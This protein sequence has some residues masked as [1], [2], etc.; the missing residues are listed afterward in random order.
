[1][2]SN[3]GDDELA[4]L[5]NEKRNLENFIKYQNSKINGLKESIKLFSKIPLRNQIII[6][7]NEKLF[8]ETREEIEKLIKFNSIKTKYDNKEGI[9]SYESFRNTFLN[10]ELS[11]EEYKKMCSNLEDEL[12]YLQRYC[13]SLDEYRSIEEEKIMY[14]NELKSLPSKIE[15]L[16]TEKKELEDEVKRYQEA[17]NMNKE[18]DAIEDMINDELTRRFKIDEL[19]Q[20][21]RKSLRMLE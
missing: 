11:I 8:S 4:R 2:D 1:M 12:I 14:L 7:E 20:L 3:E 17:L 19:I 13:E 6:E 15:S 10:D 21:A 16:M 5:D 9:D 18:I